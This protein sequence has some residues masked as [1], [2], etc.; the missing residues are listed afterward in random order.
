[1]AQ[2]LLLVGKEVQQLAGSRQ[3]PPLPIGPLGQHAPHLVHLFCDLVE[4]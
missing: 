4:F 2:A 3:R 1:L